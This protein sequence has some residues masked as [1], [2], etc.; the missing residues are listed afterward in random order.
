VPNSKRIKRL[1]VEQ[2]VR[3]SGRL[4]ALTAQSPS[5]DDRYSSRTTTVFNV[6]VGTEPF[7]RGALD[8]LETRRGYV[9]HGPGRTVG[10]RS[11]DSVGEHTSHDLLVDLDTE[12]A[13][14]LLSDALACCTRLTPATQI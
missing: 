8:V 7:D 3:G 5:S 1:G 4:V 2:S 14:D 13:G 9:P 12:S 6:A 11:V 10:A